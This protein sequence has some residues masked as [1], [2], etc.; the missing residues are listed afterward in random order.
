MV[1]RSSSI[2]HRFSNNEQRTTNNEQR[3]SDN[4]QD[5]YRFIEIEFLLKM[6]FPMN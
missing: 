4:E 6:K 3:I 1:S 5:S 2:V